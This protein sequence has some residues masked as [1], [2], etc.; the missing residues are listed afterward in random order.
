MFILG[1]YLQDGLKAVV[2]LIPLVYLI[3]KRKYL[4]LK[5][6]WLFCAGLFLL[7]FGHLLDFIDEFYLDPQ[8]APIAGMRVSYFVHDFFEDTIGFTLGFAIFILAL[9]LEFSASG[10]KFQNRG[11]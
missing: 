3:V 5:Y 8:V 9:Y 1:G 4:D 6:F 10:G 7:F 11:G 2:Y